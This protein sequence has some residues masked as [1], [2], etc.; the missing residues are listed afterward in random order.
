MIDPHLNSKVIQV[1]A[2][3]LNL[4]IQIDLDA[5]WSVL[6][7]IDPQALVSELQKA[8][9]R[10]SYGALPI[11]ENPGIAIPSTASPK[12]VTGID[13]SQIYPS[14]DHPVKWAYIQAL[15]YSSLA[16]I[17]SMSEFL[18]L[19][20]S[21]QINSD[22]NEQQIRH[23]NIDFHRTLLELKVALAVKQQY[24]DNLILMDYPLLP[25]VDKSDPS[26]DEGLKQYVDLIYQLKGASVAGIV[27]A[28][29]SF[30]LVNLIELAKKMDGKSRD[31]AD[32]ND[33]ILTC[34]GLKPGQRSAIFT[35]AGSR[36]QI[37]HKHGI[38]ICFF[39]VRIRDKD[40]VRVEIPNWIAQNTDSVN[41]IHASI[42]KDS[43]ALGYSYV[44]AKA[45]QEVTISLEIANNLHELATREFR[46]RGG[47]V[48]GSAK[49]RA[50]GF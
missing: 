48:Y 23:G 41:V 44:L 38:E 42:L 29:R 8:G 37:F 34:A 16:P 6:C 1:A 3:A 35:Y 4:S 19:E 22:I 5:L 30:L 32:V 20:T 43:E 39:F 28:P 13:G 33:T 7:Q 12:Q 21:K 11:L 45:H 49:M 40:I 2:K 14:P 9:I 24:P 17:I 25:W 47:N 46:A 10:Y 15:A 26:Y 27:S 36:N 18:D 50:K 31:I